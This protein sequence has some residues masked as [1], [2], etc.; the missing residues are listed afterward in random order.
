LFGWSQA[1]PAAS[2]VSTKFNDRIFND[3]FFVIYC[4]GDVQDDDCYFAMQSAVGELTV[5]VISS[6]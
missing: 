4:D 3:G 5:S 1:C 2:L 6:D